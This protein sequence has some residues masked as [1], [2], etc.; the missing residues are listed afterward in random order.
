[1]FL[2]SKSV[3]TDLTFWLHWSFF[4]LLLINIPEHFPRLQC[5]TGLGFLFFFFPLCCLLGKEVKIKD[6][7]KE[8]PP[9]ATEAHKSVGELGASAFSVQLQVL[10]L[11]N[12]FDF[13]FFFFFRT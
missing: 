8:Q 2:G 12:G 10:M 9:R 6:F 4:L 5:H 3:H 7:V 1:M 13:F 11:T